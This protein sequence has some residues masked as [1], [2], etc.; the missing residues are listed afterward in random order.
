MLFLEDYVKNARRFKMDCGCG[1]EKP[2][3]QD[4]KEEDECCC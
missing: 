2:K 3:K 4:S 1:C